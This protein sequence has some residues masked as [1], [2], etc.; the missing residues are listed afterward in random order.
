LSGPITK[1]FTDSAMHIKLDGVDRSYF[2]YES[3]IAIRLPCHVP[4]NFKP[5]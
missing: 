3:G 5:Q 1:A 4:S 2:R